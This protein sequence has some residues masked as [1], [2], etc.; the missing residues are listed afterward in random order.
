MS[1]YFTDEQFNNKSIDDIKFE[2]IQFE[3]C[4]FSNCNFSD[5]VWKDT[6][7]IDCEF[8]EC[9]LSNAKI[10]YTSF[11]TVRFIGCK[12]IGLQFDHANPFALTLSFEECLLQNSSFYGLNLA[13]THWVKC[14]LSEVDFAAC[15]LQQAHILGCNLEGA[16]FDNTQLQKTNLGASSNWIINPS[17]NS[18]KGMVIDQRELKGLVAHL[19]IKIKR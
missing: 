9:N 2:K 8:H 17:I 15:N 7:F 10:E 5:V 16:I 6:Q 3:D 11:Q 14:N 13:K 12:M 19:G 4:V 18:V 1:T